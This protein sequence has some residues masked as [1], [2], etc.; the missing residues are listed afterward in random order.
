MLN[1]SEIGSR[2]TGI[3]FF[4]ANPSNPYADYF[5]IAVQIVLQRRQAELDKAQAGPHRALAVDDFGV[6]YIN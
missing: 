2:S 4:G 3:N 6:Y 1:P 5:Q